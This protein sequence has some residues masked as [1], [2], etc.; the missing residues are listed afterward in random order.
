MRIAHITDPHL[1]HNLPGTSTIPRRR[2]REAPELLCGAVTDAA[3]RGADIIVV[4][5]DLVDVPMYLFEAERDHRVD[6][7]LWAAARA[8]YRLV[9]EILDD[10]G[11]PWIAIPGNHDSRRLVAEELGEDALIRD[12][13]GVRFVSFWD[14]EIHH[15]RPQR[16]LAERHRFDHVLADPGA[17]PQ[18]HLQHY[19]I[20]PVLDDGYPHTYLEGG[21]LLERIAK[22]RAVRLVLSGHYHPGVDPARHGD[23]LFSVTPALTERPHPYRM[24]SLDLSTNEV[25]WEHVELGASAQPTPAVFL[26]RDG[27]INSLAA[28]NT[29][30]EAMEIL[31]GAAQ[32]IREL[33][34]AGYRVVVVTNQTC[35]G[36]GYATPAVVD[37]VH[38]RMSKLLA[39][40]GAAVDAI[41]SSPEAGSR[42]IAPKWAGNTEAKPSPA[43]LKRAATDLGI[44]LV[45]SWMVGD[46]WTDVQAGHAAG[47]RSLLVRTGAGAEAERQFLSTPDFG[48][49]IV[50]DLHAAAHLILT[51][52]KAR[53]AQPRSS[54]VTTTASA[55]P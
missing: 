37:E 45:S 48:D 36:L 30:P 27:C 26:D 39:A 5:G 33:R 43:L 25:T 16:I 53:T 51:T 10:S 46:R 21:E 31:P 32:A 13:N 14:R 29:G 42:A 9:R 19:V 18:V 24:F 23:A 55:R 35:I 50:D 38:D 47:T 11:L 1:R 44:D 15:N 22:S 20:S 3:A 52:S 34:E 6:D 7:E 49:G 17:L 2:S 40:E 28:Y 8:D 41:Y 54:G 12:V 4:T